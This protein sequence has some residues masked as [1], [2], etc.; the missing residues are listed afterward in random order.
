MR[1]SSRPDRGAKPVSRWLIRRIGRAA[2]GSIGPGSSSVPR[3]ATRQNEKPR[4]AHHVALLLCS[5]RAARPWWRAAP[6][7]R[8]S[9]GTARRP[10][11]RG[12]R[13]SSGEHASWRDGGPAARWPRHLRYRGCGSQARSPVPSRVSSK[14]GAS[15]LC[16]SLS[17][18]A[19][20]DLRAPEARRFCFPRQWRHCHSTGEEALKARRPLGRG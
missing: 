19:G 2:R 4:Y 20:C 16:A 13:H 10:R 7:A 8:G 11:G 9:R 6:A 18:C 1:S 12:H 5:L 3:S 15:T 14:P 17:L